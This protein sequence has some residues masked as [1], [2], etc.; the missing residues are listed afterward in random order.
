MKIE[1]NS[2][3]LTLIFLHHQI[4]VHGT[5]FKT[6]FD[7]PEKEQNFIALPKL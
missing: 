3:T 1:K 2:Q 5:H 6:L 7:F 4:N